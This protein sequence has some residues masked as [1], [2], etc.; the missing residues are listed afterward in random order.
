MLNILDGFPLASLQPNSSDYLHLLIEAKKLAYADAHRFVCDP[1]FAY[2]PLT[3]L[4]SEEH[5]ELQRARIDP[6]RAA[7][8][9]T[10]QLPGSDTTLLVAADGDGNAV[11]FINSI[12]H[13]FGSGILG[14][15]TG[16]LLQNRGCGFSLDPAHPNVY[17][18]NKRPFHTIIPGMVTRGDAL[19][20]SYGLMGGP[21]QP[22]GH[23][24]FLLGHLV[25]GLSTQA[26]IDMPRWQHLTGLEVLLEHG[27][28]ESVAADLAAR[29]HQLTLSDHRPFGGAQAIIRDRAHDAY[30]GASDPRKDG[31]A[32]GY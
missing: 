19:Y 23:A 25:H 18:P 29:G 2:I 12:F 15:R 28:P 26:A 5:T 21:M 17:A 6:E 11:S 14:G 13:P 20:M 4:L 32:M 31:C 1:D 27:M 3:E 7:D 9:V 16:I 24:Q 8:G 10:A 30:L 22:Q